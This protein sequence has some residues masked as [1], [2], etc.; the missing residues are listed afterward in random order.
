MMTSVALVTGIPFVSAVILVVVP[1]Y[2]ASAAGNV[3]AMFANFLAGVSLLFVDAG[4]SSYFI[5]DDMNIEKSLLVLPVA[6]SH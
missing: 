2:R 5:V 4:A 1:G 3:L 6:C